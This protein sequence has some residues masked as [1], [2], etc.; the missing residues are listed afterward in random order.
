MITLKIGSEE[1]KGSDI[2]E[3][4]IAQQIRKRRADDYSICIK[5]VIN[6][7]DINIALSTAACAGG[8]GRQPNAK[9]QRLFELWNER[10][11]KGGDVN[12]GMVVSFLRQYRQYV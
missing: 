1:R 7:G 12:P 4:W 11:L 6:I 9:E 2:K 5:A 3:R 8:G 10:G